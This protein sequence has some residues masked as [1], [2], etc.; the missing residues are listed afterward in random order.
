MQSRS[1]E[2]TCNEIDAQLARTHRD[3]HA[4]ITSP[5]AHATL[6]PCSSITQAQP[7]G[8]LGLIVPLSLNKEESIVGVA[9]HCVDKAA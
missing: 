3:A 6:F 5:Y 2:D 8:G 1:S 9:S 7:L 4:T